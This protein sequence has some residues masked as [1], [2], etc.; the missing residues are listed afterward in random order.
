MLK[1]IKFFVQY[2][3][4]TQLK[5]LHNIHTQINAQYECDGS[6]SELHLPKNDILGAW[7]YYQ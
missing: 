2:I 7:Y 3:L 5:G 4:G 1:G 6:M